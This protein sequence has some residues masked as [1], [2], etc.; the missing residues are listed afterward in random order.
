MFRTEDFWVSSDST[1]SPRPG[2]VI[3]PN[4]EHRPPG[5]RLSWRCTSSLPGGGGAAKVCETLR[6]PQQSPSPQPDRY[7]GGSWEVESR[8][9]EGPK[10]RCS[11]QPPCSSQDPETPSSLSRR[12]GRSVL[13]VRPSPFLG[14]T[15]NLSPP[16]RSSS[17]VAS[18]LGPLA[19]T[20]SSVW[21]GAPN[22]PQG[23]GLQARFGEPPKGAL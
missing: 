9:W 6:A 12:A 5:T 10:W 8:R 18:S 3:N 21:R 19:T 17:S 4:R 11:L 2:N 13:G 1:H 14:T 7:T 22:R 15:M 16:L 23:G 20:S